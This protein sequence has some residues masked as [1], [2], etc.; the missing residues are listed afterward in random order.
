MHEQQ[1]PWSSIFAFVLVWCLLLCVRALESMHDK[2]SHQALKVLAW[3][4]KGRVGNSGANGGQQRRSAWE[5][6]GFAA[7]SHEERS[8][9]SLTKRGG[10]GAGLDFLTL[11]IKLEE[12][13]EREGSE[14]ERETQERLQKGEFF[15]LPSRGEP[16]ATSIPR[17]KAPPVSR[18]SLQPPLH[19]HAAAVA[20]R[21]R[22]T[23]HYSVRPNRISVRP[24]PNL[25][26]SD[27]VPACLPPM[28]MS[29]PSRGSTSCTCL[30]LL[31]DQPLALFSF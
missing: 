7:K 31:E 19:W 25:I 29:M 8:L 6:G 20:S 1:V 5:L 22:A 26:H 18:P 3:T 4:P 17:P 23:L 13:K 12:R 16:K 2:M 30:C 10:E 14:Q 9:W 27:L 21:T 28:H 11:I 15:F 24:S